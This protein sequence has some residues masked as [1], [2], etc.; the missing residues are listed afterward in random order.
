MSLDIGALLAGAK[1][2]GE[3]EER[4]KA[5][6]KEVSDAEGQIVLFIDEFHWVVASDIAVV[7]VQVILLLFVL[8]ERLEEVVDLGTLVIFLLP[9][10]LV[11]FLQKLGGGSVKIFI[12]GP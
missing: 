2:R 12:L 5:V 6:L 3:F 8:L 11:H 9:E 7:E 10:I 1:Y 4:L